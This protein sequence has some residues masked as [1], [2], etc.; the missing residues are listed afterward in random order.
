M[1]DSMQSTRVNHNIPERF[2]LAQLM[3]QSVLASDAPLQVVLQELVD[4][5]PAIIRLGRMGLT[6]M[7]PVMDMTVDDLIS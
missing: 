4:L 3:V 5:E 6:T 7:K 2:D 1:I